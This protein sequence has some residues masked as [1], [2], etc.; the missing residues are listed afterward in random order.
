MLDSD[1]ISANRYEK[2]YNT[3][4]VP[5]YRS[6]QP[7]PFARLWPFDAQQS[8]VTP[9]S[10]QSGGAWAGRY[11]YRPELEGRNVGT[12]QDQAD[13][14]QEVGHLSCAAWPCEWCAPFERT[15]PVSAP[16]VI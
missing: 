16:A 3:I 10:R 14:R 8:P 9:G 13:R 15:L 4:I 1:F 2:T 7:R 6:R 12:G 11:A 5:W